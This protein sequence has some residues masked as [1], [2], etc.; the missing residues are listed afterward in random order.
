MSAVGDT[1]QAVGT[2]AA[3]DPLARPGEIDLTAHVDFAA[4]GAAARLGGARWHGLLSQ[5]QFLHRL[6]IAARADRLKAAAS[7]AQVA[8]IDAAV[9]RL[10]GPAPGMGELFKVAA[11][12]HPAIP[13]LPGFEVAAA[14]GKEIR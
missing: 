2:H 14:A 6:G 7:P 8:A 3:A 1:L 12:A 5:G 13:A 10:T 9:Q 11:V 4:L